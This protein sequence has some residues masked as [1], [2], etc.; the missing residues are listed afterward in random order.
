MTDLAED[1]LNKLTIQD[2]IDPSDPV[3]PIDPDPADPSDP[4]DPDPNDPVDPIDPDPADPSDPVD[5]DPNDDI[6]LEK[7]TPAKRLQL[8]SKI[9]NMDIKDDAQL[10]SIKDK[11]SLIP[12]LQKKIDLIPALVDKI[13]KSKNVLSYFPDESAYVASQLS[14]T[15]EYKGKEAVISRI[16]KSNIENLSSTEVLELAADLEAPKGIRNPYRQLLKSAG[17]DPDVVTENYEQLSEDD[18]DTIDF[19]AASKRKTLSQLGKDVQIPR[20]DDTDLLAQIESEISSSKEDAERVRE[21][22]IPIAEAIADELK[23]LDVADGFK[24]K[25]EMTPAARKSYSDFIAEAIASGDYDLNTAKGK[26]EIWEAIQDFAWINNR[27]EIIA[28]YSSHVKEE[29]RKQSRQKLDNAAPIKKKEPA[30]VDKGKKESFDSQVK[31][32]LLS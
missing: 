22:I 27:K 11:L 28:S 31:G 19:L 13:K 12:D 17:L 21:K 8:V 18:K 5:P 25:V 20:D 10:A 32:M 15:D 4:V 2:P 1:F 24:F 14:M 16:L 3:D 26:E 29:A 23:E 30:P 9:M 7:L 6:D